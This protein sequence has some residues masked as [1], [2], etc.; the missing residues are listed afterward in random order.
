[1]EIENYTVYHILTLKWVE[2]I[3][4][5]SLSVR[6]ISFQFHL[7]VLNINRLLNIFL[8]HGDTKIGLR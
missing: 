3:F 6:Q 7:E 8:I 5:L 1:M 4:Y 2:H